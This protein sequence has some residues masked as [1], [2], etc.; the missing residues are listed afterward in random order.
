MASPEPGIVE[1]A[2]LKEA[3]SARLA[4]RFVTAS[5]NAC[6]SANTVQPDTVVCTAPCALESC[7]SNAFSSLGFAKPTTLVFEGSF[8]TA[9]ASVGPT[10]DT[11]ESRSTPCFARLDRIW[12]ISFG[13]IGN[14]CSTAAAFVICVE[15]RSVSSVM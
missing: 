11:S 13:S 12:A 9:T 14:F 8:S 5:R 10:D 3:S 6:D 7:A 4:V 2:A 15:P 1:T